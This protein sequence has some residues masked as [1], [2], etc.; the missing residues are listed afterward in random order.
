M[1]RANTVGNRLSVNPKT[2]AMSQTVRMPSP[3][4]TAVTPLNP[5]KAPAQ[6]SGRRLL[7]Q[8]ADL[9]LRQQFHR[10]ILFAPKWRPKLQ[11][12]L[13]QFCSVLIAGC[14]RG[15]AAAAA[16][17]EPRS[18]RRCVGIGE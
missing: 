12:G 7:R 15:A 6:L 1:A 11:L 9:L 4:T 18:P 16:Q 2:K 3:R 13:P 17:T 8:R 5:R 14:R 10:S